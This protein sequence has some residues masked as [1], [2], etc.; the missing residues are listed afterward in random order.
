MKTSSF[1][2]RR[3]LLVLTL[4]GAVV[5]VWFSPLDHSASESLDAGTKR[6]FV[7]FASARALNGVISFVQGTEVNAG[8]GLSAT[9]AVGEV[10]DPINDLVEQFG[11][12]MLI[13]TV[14][15]GVQE[16]LLAMGRDWAVKLALTLIVLGWLGYHLLGRGV[17]RWLNALLIL[18][19]M[20]RF[21][22]PVAA[23]GT[24]L[25]FQHFLEEDYQASESVLAHTRSSVIELTEEIGEPRDESGTATAA[26]DESDWL[27]DAL[28][29]FRGAAQAM[30]VNGRVE[31]LKAT[32]SDVADDIVRLIVVF[33]LQT[34]VVPVGIL[35]LLYGLVRHVLSGQISGGGSRNRS[36]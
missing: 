35:W 9:L 10:L 28:E 8:V 5:A 12:L 15:F 24:E 33:L 20:A 19:L 18:G 7:T 1:R 11:Q 3:V 17:P 32:V 13:A 4:L 21:A 22:I 31:A 14:S 27:S 23:V 26:E 29:T 36:E 6:A 25:V 2:E 30:D 16:V 34:L